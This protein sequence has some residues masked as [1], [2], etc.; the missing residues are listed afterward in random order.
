MAFYGQRIVDDLI[1]ALFAE[2]PAISIEGVRGVGKTT[3]ARQRATTF[4]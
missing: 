4:L 1:D 3:T 2:L